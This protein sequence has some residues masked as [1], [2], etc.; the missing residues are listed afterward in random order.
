MSRI[1]RA[2]EGILF[3]KVGTHAK[4]PLEKIIER[5]TKEIEDAG[6]AMWGYGGST[7]HP[8]TMVQ[9]FVEGYAKTGSTIYLVMHEM[10]SKHFAEQ[11]RADEYSVDGTSWEVIPK[12]I[13]VLGSRYALAIENL[14]KESFTLPLART[15]VAIGKSEGLEGSRYIK[16]RVDKACLEITGDPS[17][18]LKSDE[19]AIEIGLV[20]EL[21]KPYAVFLRNKP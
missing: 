7:C 13:N 3:M 20:A 10:E 2:G 1:I 16:G 17:L 18:P 9:P 12:G 21:V 5:K 11:V 19:P 4:E 6:Y 8:L 15:R 14:R